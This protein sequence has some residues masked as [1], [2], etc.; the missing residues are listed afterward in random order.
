MT[1]KEKLEMFR[2]KKAFI[3]AISEVFK[4]P[5]TESSV[6]DVSYEVWQKDCS[7]GTS[8]YF[9]W[10][11]V[12]YIGGGKAHRTI[13]GNSNHA[14]FREIAG[15]LDGGYYEEEDFYNSFTTNSEFFLV[16]L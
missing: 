6:A 9:E 13:T 1:T 10:L 4:K 5:S 14:N 11:V 8:R 3:E 15:L 2:D 12:H 7:D 16:Q